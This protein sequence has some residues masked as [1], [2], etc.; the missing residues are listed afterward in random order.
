MSSLFIQVLEINWTLR[1]I[2]IH[3]V[4]II[5][6]FANFDFSLFDTF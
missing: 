1:M 5:F 2:H 4:T 6:V 3:N